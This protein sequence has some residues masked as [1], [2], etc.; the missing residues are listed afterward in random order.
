MKDD[1]VLVVGGGI[2]G[3]AIARALR[4]RGVRAMVSE[5][6]AHTTT[7]GLAIN[8]PGNAVTAFAELGLKAE[9]EK[10]GRPTH[11]R[12]YRSASGKLLFEIDEDEFWGPDAAPRCVRRSDL[13]ALLDEPHDDNRRPSA[14]E[15]VRLLEG[16]AEATFADGHA[17]RHGLVVGADGVRS[18]VRNSLFPGQKSRSAVVSTAAFRIM[19]PNPG[20]AAYTAW[21]GDDSAFLLIPVDG[22]E[23][24]AF[25]SATGGGHVDADPEWL[26]RTFAAYPDEVRAVLAY[27]RQDRESLYHSPIEEIRIDEWTRGRVA[28][29][30]DAAHAT[31]PMWAQGG[32]LAV[33]DAVVIADTLARGD[34]DTAGQR[35]ERRRR[36]RVDH[37][38]LATDQFSQAVSL[39]IEVRERTMPEAGPKAYRAAYGPLRERL[40]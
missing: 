31:S 39:P 33:E 22:D 27:A 34:W 4:S 20:I 40:T 19:A 3:L 12:E 7:S 1:S 38:Q 14:V 11:R 24:Y 35:Y 10:V 18:T 21:S 6:T 15:S 8:L 17:E 5:R 16:G 29:I 37:V 25:A 2:A 26:S 32:A 9:L 13:L 23:V 28:L 30:G 36:K